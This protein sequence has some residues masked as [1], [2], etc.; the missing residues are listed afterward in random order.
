MTFGW[1]ALD[2]AAQALSRLRTAYASWPDGGRI[3]QDFVDAF[4]REI[5]QDLNTA[6]ALALVWGLVKQPLAD[7]D[8][9][10]TLR[11]CDRVLG[12]GLEHWRPCRQAIPA[13]IQALVDARQAARQAKQWAEADA[14]RNELA[15]RGFTVEDGADGVQVRAIG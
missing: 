12:L 14:L 6:R 10:A 15:T 1:A 11:H 8:K 9:K 4:T 7:A 3:D 2:G 13:D 5:N